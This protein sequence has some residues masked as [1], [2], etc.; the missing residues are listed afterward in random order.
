MTFF[1]T[2]F[3][4]LKVF[5]DLVPVYLPTS[6]LT[7]LPFQPGH[8]HHRGSCLL[9]DQALLSELSCLLVLLPKNLPPP[10]FLFSTS[11][12]FSFILG[13]NL[14]WE[15]SWIKAFLTCFQDTPPYIYWSA[16]HTVSSLSIYASVSCRAVNCLRT[17]ADR[18]WDPNVK[19]SP[20]AQKLRNPQV[21]AV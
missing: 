3:D 21:K 4:L 6:S 17:R 16:W 19:P 2:F 8:S 9:Q 10:L 14:L 20:S 5:S 11:F 1:V 18:I 15:A 7:V 12:P 13:N